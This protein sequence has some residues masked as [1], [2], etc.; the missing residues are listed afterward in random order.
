MKEG[1]QKRLA[2]AVRPNR[3]GLGQRIE[4]YVRYLNKTLPVFRLLLL[5]GKRNGNKPPRNK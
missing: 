1:W 3:L 2:L 5:R 4:K